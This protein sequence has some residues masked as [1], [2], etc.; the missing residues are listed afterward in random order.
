MKR[1]PG[2]NPLYGFTREPVSQIDGFTR[3]PLLVY[4]S[5]AQFRAPLLAQRDS[6]STSPAAAVKQGAFGQRAALPMDRF[7]RLPS[8]NAP[9]KSSAAG[10]ALRLCSASF[11]LPRRLSTNRNIYELGRNIP[12]AKGVPGFR[13]TDR[14][15]RATAIGVTR[16]FFISSEN[17]GC[18]IKDSPEMRGPH[19][20]FCKISGIQ[21]PVG[22]QNNQ[23]KGTFMT[24]QAERNRN[25]DGPSIYE[26]RGLMVL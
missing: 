25:A 22:I 17:F 8:I 3:E 6:A 11:R 23:R 9:K 20:A 21:K 12:R 15:T 5:Q 1:T 10:L 19:W 26:S 16:T 2:Q 24:T 14:R 18:Q 13:C 4:Q 7:D